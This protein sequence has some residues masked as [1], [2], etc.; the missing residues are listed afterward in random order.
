MKTLMFE[1]NQELYIYFSLQFFSKNNN[2]SSKE[3]LVLYYTKMNK[4]PN[5]ILMNK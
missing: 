1:N 3:E 5:H 4:C 2:F